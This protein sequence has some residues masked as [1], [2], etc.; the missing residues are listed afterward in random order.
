MMMMMMMKK[1]FDT[2]RYDLIRLM[3]DDLQGM[4]I[5]LVPC[6]LIL[7]VLAFSLSWQ[8]GLI[9]T[10]AL[11]DPSA[12]EMATMQVLLWNCLAGRVFQYH[13]HTV[14]FESWLV[15]SSDT[16]RFEITNTWASATIR[17]CF[18]FKNTMT[19]LTTSKASQVKLPG[20]KRAT[21]RM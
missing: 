20:F 7:F 9:S 18:A 17:R 21:P 13:Y 4:M 8:E 6:S 11:K 12:D 3:I 2:I 15:K 19:T 16:N 1:W 5:D 14:H 10:K